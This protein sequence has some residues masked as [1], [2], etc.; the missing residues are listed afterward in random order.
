MSGGGLGTVFQS[1][2]PTCPDALNGASLSIVIPANTLAPNTAY[3][4]SIIFIRE[5]TFDTNSIAGNAL[6]AGMETETVAAIATGSSSTA[7]FLSS[8]QTLPGGGI[9]FYVT[10]TPSLSYT[11]Q[12]NSSLANSSGWE[13]LLTTNA[14][15]V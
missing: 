1:L 9:A 10:T 7:P 13:S 4:A 15:G 8:P 6:L 12:F 5:L 3:Q 11:I 14:T 2:S